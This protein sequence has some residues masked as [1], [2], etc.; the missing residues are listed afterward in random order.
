MNKIKVLDK[1]NTH[2]FYKLDYKYYFLFFQSIS[3]INLFQRNKFDINN[4]RDYK[5]FNFIFKTTYFFDLLL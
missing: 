2:Y 4:F 5:I 1:S 3:K